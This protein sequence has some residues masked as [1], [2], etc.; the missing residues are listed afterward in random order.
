MFAITKKT[1]YEYKHAIKETLP[2][3]YI[4]FVMSQPLRHCRNFIQY[5]CEIVAITNN[6]T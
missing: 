5:T 4:C 6:R 2:G 1:E 3:T